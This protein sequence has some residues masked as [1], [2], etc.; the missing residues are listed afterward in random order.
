MA[1]LTRDK[2]MEEAAMQTGMMTG[3]GSVLWMAPEILLGGKYNEKIDV[4][5][6]AMCLIELVDGRLPWSGRC[7][8][9]EV[10]HKVTRSTRP[11]H[12]LGKAKRHTNNR[13]YWPLSRSGIT[14]GFWY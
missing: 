2:E 3:C 14:R 6:F 11:Q 13:P 10:P 5:S 1:G 4:F 8:A 9:A 12:Q 7:S